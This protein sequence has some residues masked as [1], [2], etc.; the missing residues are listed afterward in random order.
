LAD[1]VDNDMDP[2]FLERVREWTRHLTVRLGR[3]THEDAL[4]FV[5]L[6]HATYPRKITPG[7][8]H[9]QFFKSPNEGRCLFVEEA[10]KAVGVYGMRILSFVRGEPAG[11]DPDTCRMGLM[12]DLILAPHIQRLG[13]WAL[14]EERMNVLAVEA[15][16][17]AVYAAPNDA[18]YGA[19]I[20]DMGW[21]DLGDRRFWACPLPA[22]GKVRDPL[23]VGRHIYGFPTEADAVARKFQY[24]NRGRFTVRRDRRYLNW[25]FASEAWYPYRILWFE[26]ARVPGGATEPFGYIVVKAFCEPGTDNVWGDVVDICWAQNEPEGLSG[27]LSFALDHLHEL[28]CTQATMWLST[29]TAL[30]QAAEAIGF[31]PTARL[32]HIC[33]KPITPGRVRFDPESP[34]L[35][36][37]AD[38]ELF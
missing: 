8:Y 19:R 17:A 29:G 24:A 9:W 12:V 33:G 4:A 2:E 30:D 31:A 13:V 36:S 37:M 16:C 20:R 23:L 6:Y 5:D 34:W 10:G 18:A 32:R 26:R 7:Y 15:A 3:S 11:H 27:M 25:R 38:A 28:G 35:L 1:S 22:R 14:L 21:T